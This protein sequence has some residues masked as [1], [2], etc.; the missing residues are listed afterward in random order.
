MPNIFFEHVHT[1]SVAIV[2]PMEAGLVFYSAFLRGCLLSRQVCRFVQKDQ[3]RRS[4]DIKLKR[5]RLKCCMEVA[6]LPLAPSP[7]TVCANIRQ[8]RACRRFC[9]YELRFILRHT[10][11]VFCFSASRPTCI[12][13]YDATTEAGYS[14]AGKHVS[15]QSVRREWRDA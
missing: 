12:I 5:K 6:C 4:W 15:S 1:I 10:R 11:N 9:G 7:T 3:L 2:A 8:L 13:V 14:P